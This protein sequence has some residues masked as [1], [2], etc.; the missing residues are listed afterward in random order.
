M[1]REGVSLNQFFL[2]TNLVHVFASLL[3]G[4]FCSGCLTVF[5][6]RA[7]QAPDVFPDAEIVFVSSGGLGFINSD[8]TNT[9]H[10]KFSVQMYKGRLGGG[11]TGSGV[12]PVITGD[13]RAV[14][15]KVSASHYR[16]MQNN[17][18][19]VLW[20]AG[21]YPIL[22]TQWGEQYMPLLTADQTHLFIR[23]EQ[24]LSIYPLESCGVEHGPE[25]IYAD[26]VGNPS[27]DLRYVA[28]VDAPSILSGDDR[29]IM[30]HDMITGEETEIDVGDYP[31][32][33]RDS[34][35]LAYTGRDGIYVVN[36][37]NKTKPQRVVEYVNPI[38][39][40]Y[41]AYSH[42][43]YNVPPEVSWSPDGLWLVYHRWVV[44]NSGIDYPQYYA[45]FKVN[46]QT[47]VEVKIV[48]SGMY[49]SWRWPPQ[50]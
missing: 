36:A 48:D 41:P 15:V 47:G 37:I 10:L 33:S 35:W 26:I 21:E 2:R 46:I 40:Q 44:K 5:S 31:A 39:E 34:Q 27:P 8:G 22:C 28:H 4:I 17:N 6:Q 13:G 19:L 32:W 12:R 7:T 24:G 30:I 42:I 25:S 20:R 50:P 29:Y 45:I 14:V 38:G 9:A 3:L 23:S 1:N 43:N 11:Y 16:Y 49:P 18:P